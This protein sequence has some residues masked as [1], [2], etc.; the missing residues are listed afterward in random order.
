MKKTSKKRIKTEVAPSYLKNIDQINKIRESLKKTDLTDQEL[1]AKFDKAVK[2]MKEVIEQ[3]N[4][5]NNLIGL[6]V[7]KK[8]DE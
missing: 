8:L 7:Q 4:D 6:A 2:I 1:L 5:F 3:V